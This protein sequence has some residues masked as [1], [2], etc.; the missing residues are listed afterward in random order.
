MSLGKIRV[1]ESS[2]AFHGYLPGCVMKFCGAWCKLAIAQ[3]DT[4]GT[5]YNFRVSFSE[6]KKQSAGEARLDLS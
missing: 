1:Q 3:H 6:L 4:L 2:V 5:K